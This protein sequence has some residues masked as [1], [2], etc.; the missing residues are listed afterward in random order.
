M[1]FNIAKHKAMRLE[2]N[3]LN[4][5]YMLMISVL[6]LTLQTLGHHSQQLKE[7]I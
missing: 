1:N 6:V 3:D 5:L 7:E 4:A 2:R